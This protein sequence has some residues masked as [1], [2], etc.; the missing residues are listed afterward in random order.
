MKFPSFK[1]EKFFEKWEFN[2]P[3]LLCASDREIM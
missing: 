3:Y 2:T 1:L